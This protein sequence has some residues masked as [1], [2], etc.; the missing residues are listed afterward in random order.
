MSP[1]PRRA[2]PRQ[3]NASFVIAPGSASRSRKQL[4]LSAT[5]TCFELRKYP[6]SSADALADST[7]QRASK[8]L[9][10]GRSVSTAPRSRKHSSPSSQQLIV[11]PQLVRFERKVIYFACG[12]IDEPA[13]IEKLAMTEHSRASIARTKSEID[14]LMYGSCR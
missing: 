3:S 6:V 14:W 2:S 5:Y 7:K 12:K 1:S 10:K 13:I 9:C 8:L 4:T 11:T